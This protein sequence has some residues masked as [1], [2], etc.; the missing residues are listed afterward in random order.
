[1][2]RE[3]VG[4]ASAVEQSGVVFHIDSLLRWNLLL[5]NVENLLDGWDGPVDVEVVRNGGAVEGLRR[6]SQSRAQVERLSA[7]GARFLACNNSLR[8]HGITSG[9]LVPQVEVVPAGVVHLAV[10]QLNGWAYVRP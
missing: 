5:A 6:Q 10:R 2:W 1:M 7:K 3:D 8:A 9:Q 4:M